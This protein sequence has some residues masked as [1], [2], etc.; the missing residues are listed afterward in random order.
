[1]DD[2]IKH[3]L[4][5][6]AVL[7]ICAAIFLPILFNQP[8]SV[9]SSRDQV[10]T[11]EIAAPQISEYHPGE[12]PAPKT[13]KVHEDFTPPTVA[14]VNL[15]KP[16]TH[17]APVTPSQSPKVAK[18][19]VPVVVAKASKAAK[20]TVVAKRQLQ[21]KKV[22]Q[23]THRKAKILAQPAKAWVI[24]LG[25]FTNHQHAL[26]FERKLRRA[27]FAAFVRRSHNH[28]GIRF[29]RVLVGPESRR[30]YADQLAS[31]LSKRYHSKAIVV[32]Y[33]PSGR[34]QA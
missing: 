21:A 19:T 9:T 1:M 32:H 28:A 5:G 14:H 29:T 31:S 27:G 30:G 25:S 12:L 26:A 17:K 3:R 16:K 2:V 34:R 6:T 15:D 13:H 10:R 20:K 7:L 8:S 23:S 11:R 4:V 33:A 18:K 22:V 24:Q